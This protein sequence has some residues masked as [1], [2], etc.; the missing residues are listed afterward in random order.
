MATVG[1]LS[2]ADLDNKIYGSAQMHRRFGYKMASGLFHKKDGYFGRK[3][4]ALPPVRTL[5]APDPEPP[6]KKVYSLTK[7][8]C[9]GLKGPT[10][11]VHNLVDA[12]YTNRTYAD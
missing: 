3:V 1:R 6:R 12:G 8:Q 9:S 7:G 4:R 2:H 5:V 11:Q 10:A